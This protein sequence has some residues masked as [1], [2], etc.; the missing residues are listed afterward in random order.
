MGGREGQNDYLNELGEGKK[1]RISLK[2]STIYLKECRLSLTRNLGDLAPTF[3]TA[4]Q[5]A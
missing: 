3:S 5:C 4:E 1:L 2:K